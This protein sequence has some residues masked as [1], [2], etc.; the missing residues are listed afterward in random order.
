MRRCL[1]DPKLSISNILAILA[2]IAAL[3]AAWHQLTTRVTIVELAVEDLE[4]RM[5]KLEQT[6]LGQAGSTIEPLDLLRWKR[7]GA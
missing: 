6:G 1:L 4:F 7:A 2:V 5:E 3:S